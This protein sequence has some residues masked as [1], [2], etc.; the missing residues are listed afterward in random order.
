M[1]INV[2]IVLS[3]EHYLF[4]IVLCYKHINTFLWICKDTQAKGG[5]KRQRTIFT[6]VQESIEIVESTKHQPI[7]CL[8]QVKLILC[9][10]TA[11]IRPSYCSI[12]FYH[13]LENNNFCRHQC[14]STSYTLRYIH[15]FCYCFVCITLSTLHLVLCFQIL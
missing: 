5:R 2:G 3:E 9:H 6:V 1:E 4:P 10:K 15:Y 13:T 8:R 12:W 11:A 14:L 7:K